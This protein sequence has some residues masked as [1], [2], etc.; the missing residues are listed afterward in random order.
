M[1]KNHN[2]KQIVGKKA[3]KT[4]K[5]KYAIQPE[6][7]LITYLAGLYRLENG[8]PHFAILT[9]EPGEEIRFIHNRMPVVLEA[10]QID[11]WI[12]PEASPEVIVQTAITKMEYMEI[13]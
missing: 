3:R 13:N 11:A 7:N 12:N 10:N 6:N 5:V 9:R 2:K 4:R 1:R 8:Y